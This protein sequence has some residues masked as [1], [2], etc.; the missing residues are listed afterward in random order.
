MEFRPEY[1]RVGC[2]QGQIS[3]CGAVVSTRLID[4][5]DILMRM[6]SLGKGDSTICQSGN[7]EVTA[8][9]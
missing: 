8:V 7:V 6:D 5:I 9:N 4:I 1:S 2:G 3:I